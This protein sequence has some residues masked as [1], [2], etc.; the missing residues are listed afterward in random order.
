MKKSFSYIFG[1]K[2]GNLFVLLLTTPLLVRFLGS[3]GYGNYAFLISFFEFSVL[4][5]NAGIF[6]GARKYIS[7]NRDDKMWVNNVFFTYFWNSVVL[8]IFALI[9]INSLSQ[10]LVMFGAFSQ[11][12]LLYFFI[13]SI[14]V[15]LEQFFMFSRSVL[16]GFEKESISEPIIV[17]KRLIFGITAVFLT[18][19]GY[20]V[21]GALIGHVISIFFAALISHSLMHSVYPEFRYL[22]G[23]TQNFSPRKLLRF[24]IMTV[25]LTILVQS[26]YH[27]DI[28][29]L[30]P[31]AGSSSTG[32]YQAAITIVHFLW[33]VPVAIQITV[34]HS[35]SDLWKQGKYDKLSAVSSDI[36]R[37]TVLITAIMAV[38][39]ATLA[40]SFFPLYFGNEFTNSIIPFLILL[41]G[42]V[43]FAIAR[44]IM[45]ISQSQGDLTLLVG[46]T[47]ICALVNLLLNILLIPSY[48][49]TG[50]AVA[51]SIGYG[52]MVLVHIWTAFKLGYNPLSDTRIVRIGAISTIVFIYIGQ[53]DQF[54]N[55]NLMS[56]IVIPIIGFTLYVI[57]SMSTGVINVEE[58]KEVYESIANRNE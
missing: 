13:L 50:A 17:S 54:I 20:G 16:M 25:L 8:A 34:L 41:P 24:N 35:V 49:M 38:G 29:L 11:D 19:L 28:L 23:T 14:M 58:V 37:Y 47:A 12:F 2:L 22:G 55:N 27:M 26:L 51:T 31:L 15:S 40:E 44:P 21:T 48:G 43:G 18:Y 56:L 42:A 5:I 10:I 1:G 9:S 30:Q 39:M 45:S 52:L 46:S 36:T 57:L 4:L 3:E 32:Y 7:E 53:I 6:D 33:F